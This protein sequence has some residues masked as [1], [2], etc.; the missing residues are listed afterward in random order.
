MDVKASQWKYHLAAQGAE[1]LSKGQ[2]IQNVCGWYMFDSAKQ[3]YKHHLNQTQQTADA[4]ASHYQ[5]HTNRKC[6]ICSSPSTTV[7]LLALQDGTSTDLLSHEMYGPVYANP[8]SNSNQQEQ[9]CSLNNYN[10]NS[11]IVP[12][13]KQK[14]RKK[15]ESKNESYLAECQPVELSVVYLVYG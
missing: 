1:L 13:S 5:T 4:I 15:N 3:Q 8:N 10:N 14:N 6:S 11:M 7:Q 9:E 2:N 12:S